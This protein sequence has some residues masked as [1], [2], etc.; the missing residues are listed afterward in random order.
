MIQ[1]KKKYNSNRETKTESH[2]TKFSKKFIFIANF[3]C[4][5]TWPKVMCLSDVVH[6]PARVARKPVANMVF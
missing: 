1:Q 6:L 5:T 2:F 3:I 4:S